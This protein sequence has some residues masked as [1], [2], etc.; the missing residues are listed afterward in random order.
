MEEPT[1]ALD[2]HRQ[3]E[4]LAFMREVARQRRIIIFIAIHDRNQAMRFANKVLVIER[5][6]LR[7]AGATGEVITRQLLHD[8]Y[9]IDARIEPCSRGHL[10]IIVDSVASG[11]VA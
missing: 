2:L 4:V 10:Q 9:Q 1:S 3:M 5:G 8:V 6:Q 7:G 11:A